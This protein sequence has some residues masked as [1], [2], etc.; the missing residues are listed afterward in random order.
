M[1][2]QGLLESLDV[3]AHHVLLAESLTPLLIDAM[4]SL[5]SKKHVRVRRMSALAMVS[6]DG[7]DVI[8]VERTF[9]S[10]RRG[11][12]RSSSSVTQSTTVVRGFENPRRAIQPRDNSGE[13]AQ[14]IGEI[15]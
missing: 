7:E 9:F 8:I 11:Q 3:K 1:A 6:E 14:P 12:T 4:K 15:S 10:Q 2:V 5:P 13:V